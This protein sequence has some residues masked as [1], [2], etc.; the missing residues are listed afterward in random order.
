VPN[1]RDTILLETHHTHR[2]RLLA[3]FLYGELAERRLVN[4]N[5]RR[6]IGSM[7]MAAVICAGC[8]GFAVVMSLI[9]ARRGIG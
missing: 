8:V 1:N 6:L 2:A 5:L 9:A 4:D 3:A 7:V